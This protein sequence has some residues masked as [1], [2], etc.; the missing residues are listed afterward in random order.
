M[1]F[2]PITLTVTIQPN[3]L[4]NIAQMV[5][6]TLEDD[7]GYDV[8]EAAGVVEQELFD[9]VMLDKTFRKMVTDKIMECGV[10]VVSDPYDY[11][12]GYDFLETIPGLKRV[13]QLVK[14]MD[15]IIRDATKE[16]EVNCI[17][18]PNGYKLVRI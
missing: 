5:I 3:D 7:F 1:K 2:Q 18:V 10:E 12:D 11:F 14:E 9:A 15:D 6:D 4:Y 13:V 17:P 8:V 16:P